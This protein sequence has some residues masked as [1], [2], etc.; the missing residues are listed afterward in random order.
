MPVT[1]KDCR[2]LCEQYV[3][4]SS[5]HNAWRTCGP[6][7]WW[8]AHELGHLLTVEPNR[9][10]QPLFGLELELGCSDDAVHEARCREL[11]A[12]D[13]ARRLLRAARRADLARLEVDETYTTA[14]SGK[15]KDACAAS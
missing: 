13:V 12:M 3:P 4:F 8:H 9:F 1:L 15:V 14:G 6:D 11:A 10:G 5:R 2:E 7:T